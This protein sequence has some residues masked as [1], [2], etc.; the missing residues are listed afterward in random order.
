M[1]AFCFCFHCKINLSPLHLALI[2][3]HLFNAVSKDD[4][5]ITHMRK[6][7]YIYIFYNIYIYIKYIHTLSLIL[8]TILQLRNITEEGI[9]EL[10]R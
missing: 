9:E 10:R 2:H 1:Y 8:T 5:P 4:I 7:K 6:I 3:L